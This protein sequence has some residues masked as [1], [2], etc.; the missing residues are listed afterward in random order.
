VASAESRARHASSSTA[1]GGSRLAAEQGK[2]K[3]KGKGSD[4]RE[5]RDV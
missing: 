4:N 2:G 1:R 5:T 3:G